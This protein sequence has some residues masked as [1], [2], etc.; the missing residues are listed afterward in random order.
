MCTHGTGFSRLHRA[1]Q[2]AVLILNHQP[3]AALYC[4]CRELVSAGLR[5]LVY[6]G[7]AY[8][9]VPFRQAH[10]LHNPALHAGVSRPQ[11]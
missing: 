3:A 4:L 8:C 5:A 6:S 2:H 11:P 1:V 10:S 9:I 7:T